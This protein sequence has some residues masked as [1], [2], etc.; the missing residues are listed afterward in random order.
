MVFS[1]EKHVLENGITDK[2]TWKR[3]LDDLSRVAEDE[4]G[5]FF[6]TWFKGTGTI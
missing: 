5:T 4:K 3:G 2:A 6:Y 1:A